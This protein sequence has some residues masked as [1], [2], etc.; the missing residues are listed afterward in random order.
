MPYEINVSLNGTHY[1]ATAPR[2]LVTTQ[3]VEKAYR[4]FEKRFPKS[5]GF[6][7]S[8]RY[9]P[10]IIYGCWFEETEEGPIFINGYYNQKASK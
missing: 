9:D 3:Q 6:E 8:V 5:E 2:S 1:F 4:D 10:Q 7:L